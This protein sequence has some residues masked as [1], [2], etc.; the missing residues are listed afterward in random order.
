VS[1]ILTWYDAALYWVVVMLTVILAGMGF[2]TVVFR[3]VLQSSLFWGDE[4]LRYVMIWLVFL[5][6]AL[7]T[8]HRALITVDIFTQPMARRKRELIAGIV[9]LASAA[10]LGYLAAVSLELVQRSVGTVSASMGMPMDRMYLVFPIGLGLT[11]INLVREAAARFSA[12]SRDEPDAGPV[13]EVPD[14]TVHPE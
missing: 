13:S 7:A 12:A 9:A 1:R 5:G 10:F 3:Y 11:A 6:A 4:F 14:L 8:R 2:A